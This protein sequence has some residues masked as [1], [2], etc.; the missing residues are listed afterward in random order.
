MVKDILYLI[1]V[2]Y[3]GSLNGH[4]GVYNYIPRND[5]NP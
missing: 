2:P 4:V 1:T 3:A 5:L